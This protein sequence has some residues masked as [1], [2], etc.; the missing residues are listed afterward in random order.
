[1]TNSGSVEPDTPSATAR[2]PSRRVLRICGGPDIELREL[3]I[4]LRPPHKPHG[5]RTETDSVPFGSIPFDVDANAS[6][7]KARLTKMQPSFSNISNK[8][9]RTSSWKLFFLGGGGWLFHSTE[10]KKS[11]FP[12]ESARD[13][14]MSTINKILSKNGLVNKKF[15]IQGFNKLINVSLIRLYLSSLEPG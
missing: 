7:L 9:L 1:M 3:S 8:I 11:I 10:A 12:I 4:S 14:V 15:K 6:T 13:V 2:Q 5:Y